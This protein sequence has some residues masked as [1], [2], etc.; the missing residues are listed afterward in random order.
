MPERRVGP[1]AD[2]SAHDDGSF[3]TAVP[4]F[5]LVAL[6]LLTL[7]LAYLL[8]YLLA[9]PLKSVLLGASWFGRWAT[10]LAADP[11]GGSYC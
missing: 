3:G 2:R 7:A 5:F 11:A 10:V 8:E 6:D 4:R 1:G 9:P